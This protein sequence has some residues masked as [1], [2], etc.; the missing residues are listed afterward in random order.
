MQLMFHP[1]CGRY[2]TCLWI[3]ERHTSRASA[4][5]HWVII[6]PSLL[7][8]VSSSRALRTTIRKAEFPS[9]AQA[10]LVSSLLTVSLAVN[11]FLSAAYC[12]TE[13]ALWLRACFF[14]TVTYKSLFKYGI[15]VLL[16]PV[17][18][19]PKYCPWVLSFHL[20]R[21]DSLTGSCFCRGEK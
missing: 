7:H 13:R 16:P 9:K 19:H 3:N 6:S 20:K 15:Q 8:T 11:H 21:P 14:L 17:P 4:Q 1:Q 18:C 12:H 10:S 5:N 2:S